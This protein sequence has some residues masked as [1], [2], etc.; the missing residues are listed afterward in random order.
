MNKFLLAGIL[1][2]LPISLSGQEPTSLARPKPNPQQG[3]CGA[4]KYR[5]AKFYTRTNELVAMAISIEPKYVTVR[6]LLTLACQL[7]EDYSAE[8]EVDA[9]IFNDERAAKITQV[10]TEIAL[11][12]SKY[13]NPDAYLATYRLDR[14]KGIETLALV[15]DP[16]DPCGHDIQIELQGKKVSI[17][18]C[19]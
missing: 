9:N 14:R 17:V 10:P 4:L 5:V 8:R 13:E 11:E 1:L 3:K 15:I 18:S 7:R 19:E 2:S 6:N 16:K 12:S